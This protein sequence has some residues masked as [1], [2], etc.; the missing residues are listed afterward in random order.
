[1]PSL[2]VPSPL[3]TLTLFSETLDVGGASGDEALVAVD[4]GRGAEANGSPFLN[5]VA[6]QLDEYFDG[7]REVFDLPL[8]PR[9]TSFQQAVWRQLLAIPYA[10]TRTYGDLA[11]I[12]GSAA[13]AV[14]QACGRNP[15]PVIIPCHRVIGAGRR[16]V[17]FSADG[18]VDTK[19]RL[20][21]LEGAMLPLDDPATDDDATE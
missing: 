11:N 2:S 1:M 3:G 14:G 16:L 17:G 12:L 5:E 7:R 4:W 21:V 8:A 18:G 6:R 9:G 10:V 15:I 13:R 19:R 20:L